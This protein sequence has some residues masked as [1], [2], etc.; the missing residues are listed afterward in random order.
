[1][2]SRTSPPRD[3]LGLPSYQSLKGGSA[4][5]QLLRL[6]AVEVARHEPAAM[7]LAISRVAGR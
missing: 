1:M 2:T 4:V 3:C 5:A 6:P 7:E